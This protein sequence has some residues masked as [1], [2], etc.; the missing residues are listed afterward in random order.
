MGYEILK[1][2]YRYRKEEIDI[3]ARKDNFII[4]VEVKVSSSSFYGAPE[5]FGSRKN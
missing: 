4:V 1:Q 5:S 3:I 2:N